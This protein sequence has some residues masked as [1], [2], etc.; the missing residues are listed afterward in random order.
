VLLLLLKG[1]SAVDKSRVNRWIATDGEEK[2]NR[3]PIGSRGGN[4]SWAHTL[5]WVLSK[6]DKL[7]QF[8]M[9]DAY[10]VYIL[11]LYID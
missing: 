7:Q 8:R 5:C 9:C 2:K 4:G 6:I 10:S 11:C 1:G 3:D